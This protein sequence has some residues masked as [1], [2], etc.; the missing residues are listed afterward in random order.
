MAINIFDGS[1]WN[2]YKKIHVYDGSSWRQSVAAYIWDGTQWVLFSAGTPVNTILPVLSSSTSRFNSLNTLEP[3]DNVSVDTGTW[4]N[5]PTSYTY[6]WYKK[7]I[8]SSSWEEITGETSSSI[9]LTENTLPSLKYVGYQLRC[10]VI[11]TNSAGDS[12][13]SFTTETGYV[14]PYKIYNMVTTVKSNN[15]VEIAF[16]A[17]IGAN[18][19]YIQYQGP[20]VAFTEIISLVNNTNSKVV[21]SDSGFGTIKITLDLDDADGTLGFLVNPIRNQSG[22][23]LTGYGLNGS[24]SNL[25]IDPAGV[26]P[27]A[28]NI[29]VSGFTFNWIYTGGIVPSSWILYDGGE[30]VTSSFYNGLNSTSV[31]VSAIAPGG[32][33]Y[34]AY[35]IEV[36]GSAPRHK[37]TQWYS[38]FTV[39]ITVPQDPTPV[40]T[41]AP[42]VSS[43]DGRSFSVTSGTWTNSSYIYSYIYDWKYNGQSFPFYAGNTT[44]NLGS[45]TTYDGASISCTVS[46]LTTDLR[47]FSA[48]GSNS[49]TASAYSSEP[50]PQIGTVS[51]SKVSGG[52]YDGL[53]I[54]A[55]SSST[56][57]VTWSWSNGTSSSSYYYSS[58]DFGVNL[59]LTA[60]ATSNGK[61]VSANSSY[62]VTDPRQ[63]YYTG[64]SVCN[65]S[66]PSNVYYQ[67]PAVSGPHLTT[68]STSYAIPSDTYG[69]SGIVSLSVNRST[70]DAA[71]EAA[72]QSACEFVNTFAPPFFPPSFYGAPEPFAPPFFPPFFPPSFY[73][74]PEPFA[75]PFFP[76]FFPP[77]FY[78][79]PE[80]FAPPFFPPSFGYSSITLKKNISRINTIN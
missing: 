42:V 5:T 46:I 62:Y 3:G 35:S 68:S 18:D 69:S 72:R 59:V 48:L 14:L 43:S 10:G 11:A 23:K 58:D 1:N 7:G 13:E 28:S 27:Y 76:P 39:T 16:P 8:S 78:G 19:Y 57:T 75:P 45:S 70:Y 53:L 36:N 56:G 34:G 74:A 64:T 33:T 9:T 26:L 29:S 4:D 63:I 6:K 73:S 51:I 77:S 12:E 55:V 79:A 54:G 17:S 2:Q 37:Q 31:S 41:S 49:I 44:I 22:T 32:T 61:S 40:N 30:V 25:K 80:P 67:S 52:S 24:V 21:Y 60:T 65:T 66:A 50:D 47:T 71:Y 38:P 15:I 20:E